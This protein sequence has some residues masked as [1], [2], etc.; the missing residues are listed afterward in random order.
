MVGDRMDTDIVTG[1]E[2]GMETILVLSG[3]TRQEEI[4]RYPLPPKK[5]WHC[6]LSRRLHIID[7][8]TN[9]FTT[10]TRRTQSGEEQFYPHNALRIGA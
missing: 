1:M 7:C 4:E 9:I 2:A 3:L 5:L 6:R 8:R 10:K